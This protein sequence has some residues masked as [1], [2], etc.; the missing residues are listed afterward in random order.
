MYYT[1]KNIDTFEAAMQMLFI[2][3]GYGIINHIDAMGKRCFG[4]YNGRSSNSYYIPVVNIETAIRAIAGHMDLEGRLT[5]KR[6]S[7]PEN[8]MACGERGIVYGPVTGESIIRRVQNLYYSGENRFFFIKKEVGESY[9]I[10]DPDGFPAAYYTK[11]EMEKFFLKEDG[12]TVMLAK[13]DGQ[14]G[15]NGSIKK[16]WTEGWEFYRKKARYI[17]RATGNI[18]S[19]DGF[20]GRSGERIALRC[21][22]A[23][24]IQQMEKIWY[25]RGQIIGKQ[26]DDG[27]LRLLQSNMQNEAEHGRIELLPEIETAIW[28]EIAD[29]T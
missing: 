1:G 3:N 10:A 28:K 8:I 26:K 2:H 27:G 15:K 29:E 6:L 17:E 14:H 4:F 5:A 20:G 9:I 16:I 7:V 21:G 22:V 12:V 19:F 18:K 11:E 13:N 25:L 23:N 24:Y